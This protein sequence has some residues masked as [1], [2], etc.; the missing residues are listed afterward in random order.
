MNIVE[1]KVAASGIWEEQKGFRKNKSTIDV[2]LTIRKI[3]GKASELKK[4]AL[5]YFVDLT[6]ASDRVRIFEVVSFMKKTNINSNIIK[7]ITEINRDNHIFMK[8][9]CKLSEEVP[10]LTGIKQGDSL[11]PS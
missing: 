11:S 1:E 5:I 2:I 6:Q 4:K 7:I 9:A 8:V 3:T 10:I